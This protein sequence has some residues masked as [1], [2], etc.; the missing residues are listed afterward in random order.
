[1]CTFAA[2]N[3]QLYYGD[4]IDASFLRSVLKV[5]H[6]DE[7]YHFAAQSNVHV[8]FSNSEYTTEVIVMGTLRIL[9]AIRNYRPVKK[10]KF[11]NVSLVCVLATHNTLSR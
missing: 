7:V 8:S 3:L 9:E 5:M 6:P 1:M 4:I 2:G 11:Y 10:V